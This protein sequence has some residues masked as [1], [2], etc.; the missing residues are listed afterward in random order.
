MIPQRRADYLYDSLIRE[1]NNNKY[2]VYTLNYNY[3]KNNYSDTEQISMNL[4][5][6][7]QLKEN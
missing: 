6:A 7:K 2:K 3:I 4:D 5:E 1:F